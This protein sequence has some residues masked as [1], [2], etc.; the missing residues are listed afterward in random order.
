LQTVQA[1]VILGLVSVVA[2][3]EYFHK[4]PSCC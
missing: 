3:V 4:P 1:S 2:V